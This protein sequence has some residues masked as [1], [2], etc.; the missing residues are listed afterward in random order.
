M[1][2]SSS[3]SKAFKAAFPA[4][5]PVLTGFFVLGLAYGIL[6]NTKGYGPL[7]SFTFSAIAFCGSMQF[8]AIPFLTS[9]FA[10]FEV[11][12]LSLMVNARHVFYGLSL[13]GKYK[14]AGRFKFPLIYYMCDETFAINSSVTVPADIKPAH[15][16]FAVTI[17]HAFYWS[18]SSLL[19]GIIGTMLTI[20]TSGLDFA[21]TALFIVLFIEQLKTKRSRLCG[22][23]GIASSLLALACFGPKNMVI[24]AM[25]FIL[26]ALLTGRKKLCR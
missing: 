5:L 15:F 16:Y 18:V 22:L 21:L 7:W 8:V 10:P 4:T 17:L 11:F 1:Q 26:A 20:N 9:T 24:A 3:L 25:F 12:L 6:M 19:G 13:L 23:I 2:Y 14:G